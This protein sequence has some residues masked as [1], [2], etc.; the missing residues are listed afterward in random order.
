[1]R[2]SFLGENLGLD[3]Q[4]TICTAPS[5]TCHRSFGANSGGQMMIIQCLNLQVNKIPI[6][7]SILLPACFYLC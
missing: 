6:L 7:C 1:M 4:K 5:Q 2:S 3:I